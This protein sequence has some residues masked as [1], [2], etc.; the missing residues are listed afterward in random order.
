MRPAEDL[1]KLTD[2]LD[3]HLSDEDASITEARHAETVVYKFL[4]IRLDERLKSAMHISRFDP[5]RN[6]ENRERVLLEV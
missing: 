6:Q 5:I 3:V 1:D 4:K 2:E